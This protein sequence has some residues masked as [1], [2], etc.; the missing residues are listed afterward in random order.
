MLAASA[1]AHA[2]PRLR[3]LSGVQP[4]GSIHLGNY[5]GAIR[6]WVA[7]QETYD[8]F[9]CVVDLHAVTAPHEPKL[10]AEA[11]RTVAALYLASGVDPQRSTVFVQS[12]V[13]AHSELAWLLNCVTPVGWLGKMIQFKE[14]ARKQGEE[15]SMGLMDYPV[16]TATDILLY[17][18][19]LVPVG[20]DQRQHLELTRD[21]S[22]RFN[23][24][25]G[26]KALKARKGLAPSGR[27]RG[28]RVLKVPKAL[29]P[30]QGARV[31]S[32]DDGS[33]KLS[34][35]N[36]DEG[37]RINLLDSAA[38]IKRCKTDT[39]P[40]LSFDDPQRPEAANLLTIYQLC[41]GQSRAAVKQQCS[42]LRWSEFKPLPAK[43]VVEHLRPLQQRYREITSEPVLLD[44][45]L[46][47]GTET[48]EEAAQRTLA[49]VQDALSYLP[50]PRRLR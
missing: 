19:D 4:T 8:T 6:N 3:V 10:L 12:H 32:L 39:L 23:A 22:G 37:S 41:S 15:V 36:P 48:A 50:R 24:L 44:K 47:R 46:L 45:V 16:L 40:A 13:T 30:P 49:D 34:K 5:L 25:Y 29:I 28:G 2:P 31:M 21:I 26:G 42:A 14:K 27:A 9:Y 17:S 18:A 7:L 1:S 33:S 35:S 20:E 11:T 38:K 43:A